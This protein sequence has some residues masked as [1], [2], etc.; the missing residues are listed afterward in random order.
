MAKKRKKSKHRKSPTQRHNAPKAGA[1]PEAPDRAVRP[2]LERAQHGKVIIPFG[3]DKN[4]RPAVIEGNDMVAQLYD[5]KHITYTQEQ[6]ARTFQQLHADYVADLGIS[7]G[8][9]CLD[10]GPVGHDEGEGNPET[11]ARHRKIVRALGVIRDAELRLVVLSGRKP[12]D[13]RILRDAL[14]VVSN[15]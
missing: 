12:R 14:D 4:E 8:R 10:I 7:T 13:L 5:A 3:M 6:A 1:T 11:A 2:T 9:S 15:C